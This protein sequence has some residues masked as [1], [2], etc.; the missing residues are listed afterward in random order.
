MLSGNAV[1]VPLDAKEMGGEVPNQDGEVDPLEGV[2]V[3]DRPKGVAEVEADSQTE[4]A[5]ACQ[6]VVVEVVVL[7]KAVVG[8]GVL[9]MVEEVGARDLSRKMGQA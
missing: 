7:W 1:V 3:V 6:T 2:V 8:V 5:A 9:R 4:A